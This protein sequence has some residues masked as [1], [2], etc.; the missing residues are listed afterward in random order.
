[1][2]VRLPSVPLV[3]AVSLRSVFA[4]DRP[5]AYFHPG[6]VGDAPVIVSCRCKLPTLVENEQQLVALSLCCVSARVTKWSVL[7][8]K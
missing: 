4:Y 2:C 8:M 7:E 1:M 3:V 5:L 6:R